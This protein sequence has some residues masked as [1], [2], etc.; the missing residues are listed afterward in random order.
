MQTSI[1]TVHVHF[2][3]AFYYFS[4]DILF[5]VAKSATGSATPVIF[6]FYIAVYLYK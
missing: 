1:V 6:T 3:L 4:E 5:R 2:A